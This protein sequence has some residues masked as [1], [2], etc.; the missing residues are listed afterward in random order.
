MAET[1]RKLSSVTKEDVREETKPSVK[2]DKKPKVYTKEI[3]EHPG[4][5]R[6]VTPFEAICVVLHSDSSRRGIMVKPGTKKMF[7]VNDIYLEKYY[8]RV[9]GGE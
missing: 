3:K 7:A 9:K 8:R 5:S 6:V 4:L 1:K 2:E